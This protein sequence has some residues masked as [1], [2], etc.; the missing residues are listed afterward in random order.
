MT[1]H[2]YEDKK[3]KDISSAVE[4]NFADQNKL[5]GIIIYLIAGYVRQVAILFEIAPKRK[6]INADSDA[7]DT[8]FSA[9]V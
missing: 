8:P 3:E 1:L 9:M 2:L 7:G 6:A 4:T 5:E